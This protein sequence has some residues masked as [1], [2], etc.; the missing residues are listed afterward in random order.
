MILQY[1]NGMPVPYEATGRTHQKSRTRAALIAAVH[2]LLRTG[3][4]PTVDDVAQAA[5]ISRTTAYR[6]FPNQHEL[7]VAAHPEIDAASLLGAN[8]PAEPEARLD[9]VLANIQQQI[10]KNE[11]EL[12]TALR[13]SLDPGADRARLLVRQGRAIAWLTDALRPLRGRMSDLQLHRLVL[14]IRA[15]IGIEAFVWLTDV[16]GLSRAD[17]LALMRQSAKTLFASALQDVHEAPAATKRAPRQ[18]TSAKQ[19]TR[20]R[21]RRYGVA[22]P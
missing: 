2:D 17:A 14:A 8:P 22:N 3:R 10:R 20:R 6:Y 13:L 5:G 9:R 16:A 15:T 19:A 7:L 21:R 12:R 18:P 4:T 11:P 1:H